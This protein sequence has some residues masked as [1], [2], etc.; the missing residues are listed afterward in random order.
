MLDP[1][2]SALLSLLPAEAVGQVYVFAAKPGARM[3]VRKQKYQN[4]N[5]NEKLT[6]PTSEREVLLLNL[7]V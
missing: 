7:P 6:V 2:S 3:A 4:D 5:I 1:C